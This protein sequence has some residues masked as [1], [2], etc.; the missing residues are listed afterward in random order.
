MTITARSAKAKGKRLEKLVSTR[1]EEALKEFNIHATPTPMSGAIDRFKGDIFTN[2][3]I[4]FEC[5]NQEKDKPWE[6]YQQSQND[7]KGKIPV[8]VFSK[9]HSQVLTLVEFE[10]LLTI[11]SYAL[12]GGLK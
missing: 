6:W 9:N 3:P 5:K 10:D 8:V 12:K 1:L 11:L 7:A 2:L 4:N